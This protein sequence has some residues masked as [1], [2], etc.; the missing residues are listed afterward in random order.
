MD[1]SK[2]IKDVFFFSSSRRLEWPPDPFPSGSDHFPAC[3]VFY[4]G[5]GED[6]LG[7]GPGIG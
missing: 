6:F 7:D 1:L 4:L 5:V 3:D 2:K